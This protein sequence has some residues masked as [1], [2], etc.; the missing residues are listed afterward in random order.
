MDKEINT[1]CPN[2]NK[3][4]IAYLIWRDNG[5]GEYKCKECNKDIIQFRRRDS[6]TF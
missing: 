2:C 6:I 4:V 5:E 3:N 1:K